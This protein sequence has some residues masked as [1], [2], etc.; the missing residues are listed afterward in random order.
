MKDLLRIRTRSAFGKMGGA[1]P[2]SFQKRSNALSVAVY[3]HREPFMR[4]HRCARA[5]V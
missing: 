3:N 4:L 1:K 5:D 2:F